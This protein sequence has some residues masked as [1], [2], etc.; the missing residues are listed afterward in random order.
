MGLPE[1][2]RRWQAMPSLVRNVTA[3]QRLPQRPAR[4]APFP[5]DLDER[6]VGALQGRG[7]T[8][9]YT[10]QAAAVQAAL[11]GENVVVVTPTASGKTLCYNLP[12]LQTLL[13]VPQARALYLFPTKALAQDQ[14]DEL[15]GM[16]RALR[17]SMR[18]DTY[19]GDTPP[20]ARPAIRQEARIVISN[21]DMLHTGIL[22][23]HTR[24]A[25]F[26]GGLRYVVVDELHSYRGVFGSHVAN[27]LRRLRR[28]A[29]FYGS[30]PQFFCSSATIANPLE[31]AER[32][33]E[34]PFTLVDDDGAP[35]GEK[36]FVLYNPPLVRREL[37]IRRSP[38]LEARAL[39]ADL[40]AEDV[41][42]IV[43]ARARQTAE[44]LLTYLRDFVAGRGQDAD[45]VRGYRGGYLPQ[46][47]REIEAGLR[48]GQV[49]GVV[50]TNALELGIDIGALSASVMTGY[51]G[52]IAS[53]WQQAGRAGRGK[54][55]SLA[56]LVAGPSPL[57]QYLVNHPAYF[58]GRSPEQGLVNPD[59]LRILVSHLQCA[60][61]EL[62]FQEG[63]SF[64]RFAGTREV[65]DYL[66]EAGILRR[67]ADLYHW[68]QESYPAQGVSL[69]TADPDNFLVIEVPPEEEP[70]D[71]GRVV[72][73]VDRA[74]APYLVH[75]GAIYIHEGEQY[76]VQD[77]DWENRRAW[78]R[79][80]RVGY[81]TDAGQSTDIQVLETHARAPWGEVEQAYGTV[82]VTSQVT[83]Y[84]KIRLYTHENLGW[85]PLEL[86]EQE[87]DTTAWWLALP[88]AFVER[89][90][91][92]GL[93]EVEP[94]RNYGPNWEEQRQR[95]LA[96]DRHTCQHCGAPERPDRAHDVHH[97]R[98]FREFG[99]VPGE[100]ET[101]LQ[102]N[103]LGNLVTLCRD[104]HR[105][106]ELSQRM[107]SG[108][109]GLGYV[110]GQ[111][112]PL[113]LMC[114][115]RDLGVVVEMRSRETRLPTLYIYDRLPGGA[116]F[117]ERLFDLVG[118][119]LGAAGEVVRACPCEGGCPSCVG[120]AAEAGPDVKASTLGLVAA[121]V[122]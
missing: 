109:S 26:F 106:A 47:R 74:S 35:K 85:V 30:R 22:P 57:D 44:I 107:R 37:G 100:N 58:F 117:S 108:L 82:R 90:R 18:V 29:A 14:L 79:P 48:E 67:A 2:L 16:L 76:E 94:I 115:P 92:T 93:W 55:I 73:Q 97:I 6:L 89:L 40:L 13:Q 51:P 3:W 33:A 77:L 120:P 45:R 20:A 71:G 62:P 116:G 114:D 72:G 87:M 95:A 113:Y 17:A 121:M 10:H 11:A 102:A 91:A 78:V 53:T 4:C 112:A 80:V 69:R 104:C 110:L 83:G 86:P 34:A 81:Y 111:V 15:A 24:W 84:R 88:N 46:E 68:M 54:E 31:L 19:D 12:V 52:T 63:E 5:A 7:I 75:P 39:A 1:L 118:E 60:A 101:Y 21:P 8:Q 119:L 96:R 42:T 56:L 105:L 43:F 32:L 38:V 23:H 36:H 99:Y 41:Q 28:V 27:V 70:E 25:T 98:P 66:A 50:A 49:R 103:D 61:F 59:N 9:L 122:S 65:L 64:G